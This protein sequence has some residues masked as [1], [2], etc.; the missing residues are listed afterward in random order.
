MNLTQNIEIA[1]SVLA[2]DFARLGD[3]IAEADEG[4]ADYIHLDVMDGHFVPNLTFGVPIIAAVRGST[5][6]VFDVHMMVDSPEDYIDELAAAGA[7]IITVHVEA[8]DQLH[9][10]IKQIKDSGTLAG[11]ALSPATPVTTLQDILPELDLVLIM[12]V[13]PGF[14]GQSFIPNTIGK[15]EQVRRMLDDNG[16]TAKLEVDGGIGPDNAEDVVTAGARVL[17]AGSAVY[18]SV[19]GVASAIK[20]I[21]D[22]ACRGL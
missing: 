7:D 22:A 12:S 9:Q 21:R 16:L 10:V 13:N 17:V 19:D 6:A 14:G 4:G 15:I 18:S 5:E 8:V 2:A 11:L 3:Q 1:P 20:A